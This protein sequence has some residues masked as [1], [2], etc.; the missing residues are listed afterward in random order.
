[1]NLGFYLKK[2]KNADLSRFKATAKKVSKI[3]GKPWPIVL[4]DILIC[5]AKYGS[6]HVDYDTFAMYNMNAKERANILTITKNNNLVKMLN[7]QSYAHYF[8]DK[9]DFDKRFDKY[10]MR[11]WLYLKDCTFEDFE[12]FVGKYDEFYAKPLDL[13]CGHGIERVKVNGRDTR[14]LYD[15]LMAKSCFLIEEVVVQDERIAR[16]APYA[17]NTIRLITILNGDKVSIVAGCLRMSR[18]GMD[19]DNFNAGGFSVIVN[20]KDGTIA[21]DGY[22]KWRN[23]FVNA[24][25]TG[26]P[27][28]GYQLPEWDKVCAL[29]TEAAREIPQIRYVGWDVCVSEK[30]GPLLI[31]GNSYPGQDVTQY[32][33]LN[34]GTYSVM[35]E[36]IK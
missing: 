16:L 25:D 17:V 34:Q 8:E 2:I 28:K 10:L 18:K 15:E 27:L 26:I 12:E 1:M 32:P 35:M 20:L 24:P 11:D 19:V 6:G 7:D 23:T 13:C 33:A 4:A 22:D 9:A 30:Y 3:N 14:E 5:S 29:V 21:T 31:E 36:A